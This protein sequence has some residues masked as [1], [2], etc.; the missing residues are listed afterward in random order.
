[1]TYEDKVQALRQS[2]IACEFSPEQIELIADSFRWVEF[3]SDQT[4]FRQ[5][6]AGDSLMIVVEGRVKTTVTDTPGAERF[7]DHLSAGEHFGEISVLTGQERSISATAVMDTKLLELDRADYQTLVMKV[8]G[9]AANL[10]RALGFRLRRETTR[11][12]VRNVSRVI[13]IVGDG[14]EPVLARRMLARLAES[15]GRETVNLRIIA[16]RLNSTSNLENF[17]VSEIP[18]NMTQA[19]KSDWVQRRLSEQ[20]SYDGHTLV[21]LSN[22]SPEE[23]QRILV[24]CDK[25]LWLSGLKNE[26]ENRANLQSLL[27]AESRLAARLHWAWLLRE[28]VKPE[29]IPS[30]PKGLGLPDF[31]IVLSN[32]RHSSRLEKMGISRLVRFIRKTRLGLALG[33]GAARGLAH[34]GVIKAFEEQGIFFDVITGT[35][36]GAL[37]AVPYAYGMSPDEC[38]EAFL[39]DLSPGWAFRRLPKGNE[40]YMLYQ[41]RMGK[42]DGL[43]RNRL[44]DVK[45]EQ[46]LTPVSTVSVDLI[47]GRQVIRDSGDATHAILES[48]NIPHI[49][50]PIMRDGMALVDG[51]IINNI[52]SDILAE[53][54]ADLTVGINIAAQIA[55]RFGKNRFGMPAK[56]MRAPSQLQTIM[57]ANEVQD[58]QITALRTKTVDQMIVVDTSM[59]DFADFTKAREMSDAGYQAGELVL[60][61]FQ[62]MLQQQRASQASAN[63]RFVCT[64]CVENQ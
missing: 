14:G 6:D 37:M 31:K 44:G 10:S 54:G 55:Q 56:L 1:M 27:D 8:P 16:D 46:L 17:N 36:A 21:W 19:A 9:L 57:R 62:R 45:L 59:F 35:S 20:S 11:K 2:Q 24:Q 28:G 26:N 52:P 4:V 5:N 13:G 43:L 40:W 63:E 18:R 42:W 48:I 30:S 58:H 3:E 50:K 53:R 7:V 49:S 41:F 15:L 34:L 12:K 32:G 60:G 23:Q 25:V 47:T 22:S 33:G 29:T 51:G 64:S 61:R 38:T 39:H